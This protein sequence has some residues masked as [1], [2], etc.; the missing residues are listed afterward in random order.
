[1]HI[2]P[3]E[4]N[5]W[6]DDYGSW[7]TDRAGHHHCGG[8]PILSDVAD[9]EHEPDDPH[10]YCLTCVPDPTRRPEVG[11]EPGLDDVP[12]FAMKGVDYE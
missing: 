11:R 1:M 10:P 7:T 9:C 12:M 2:A 6:V 8:C 5:N 3:S 4:I